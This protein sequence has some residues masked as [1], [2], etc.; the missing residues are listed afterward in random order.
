MYLSKK[1]FSEFFFILKQ[2]SCVIKCFWHGPLLSKAKNEQI[3]DVCAPGD[4]T[5]LI[6][7]DA[8]NL[9]KFLRSFDIFND[10]NEL[11]RELTDLL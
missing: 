9:K 2:T 4:L 11:I 1:L 3:D 5:D 10:L 7:I 6:C 8:V